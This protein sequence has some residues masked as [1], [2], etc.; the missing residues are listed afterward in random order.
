[1]WCKIRDVE[2]LRSGSSMRN[3]KEEA[4]FG[5]GIPEWNSNSGAIIAE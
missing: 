2:W 4:E 1:M 5:R 3:T